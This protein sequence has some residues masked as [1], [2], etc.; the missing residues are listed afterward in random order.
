MV[1]V[2]SSL[3]EQLIPSLVNI[4]VTV[5][6]TTLGS[7]SGLDPVNVISTLESVT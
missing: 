1:N 2:C 7:G 4:G 6:V 5:I 3:V